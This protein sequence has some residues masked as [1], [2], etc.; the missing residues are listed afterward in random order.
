MS[1]LRATARPS[2]TRVASSSDDDD[3]GDGG[4]G[5]SGGAPGGS[6]DGSL[7]LAE[8]DAVAGDA[9]AGAQSCADLKLQG[10]AAFG[11]GDLARAV[12]LYTAALALSPPPER[13]LILSNRSAALLK[14]H[15]SMAR[16]QVWA[17]RLD[18]IL[19]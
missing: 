4:G 14:L 11:R 13:H 18:W 10:N 7:L 5:G 8:G 9:V 1:A 12:E 2:E 15:S 19:D 3:E 16:L 6:G 17:S